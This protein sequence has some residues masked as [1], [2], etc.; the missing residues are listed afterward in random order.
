MRRTYVCCLLLTGLLFS[1]QSQQKEENKEGTNAPADS[2]AVS[3][4]IRSNMSY[5]N[6]F[7]ALEALFTNDNW[8]M[9]DQKDSSYFYFSRV[10]DYKV[11]TYLYKLEKGDSAKVIHADM[12]ADKN[13]LVWNFNQ[14]PL[15]LVSATNARA[16]W[17]VKG[18]DSVQYEFIRIDH[19]HLRLTYPDKKQVVMKKML[20]FSLFLVRSRYD[21]SNGTHYAFDTTQFNRKKK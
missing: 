14:Q 7:N 11:N 17:A 5:L 2:A 19:E 20:P 9:P 8:L 3:E 18:T 12:L 4:S 6:D 21:F 15:Y 16:V 10:N 1:C 13:Q